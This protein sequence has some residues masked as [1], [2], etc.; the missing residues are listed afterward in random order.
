MH[1]IIRAATIRCL[2]DCEFA[3]VDRQ[4]YKRVMGRLEQAKM[5]KIVEFL[6]SLPYFIS[7]TRHA[8]AKLHYF[9]VKKNVKRGQH[10]FSEGE[11]ADNAFLIMEGEF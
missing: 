3:I 5:N 6:A 1:F 8:V 9:F 7:W 4:D 11:L 10:I 2:T